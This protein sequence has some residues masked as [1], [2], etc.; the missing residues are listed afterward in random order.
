MLGREHP[1]TLRSRHGLARE[2]LRAHRAAEAEQQLRSV[3]IDRI[4][5]LGRRHP[6]TL[7]NRHWLAFALAEQGAWD[8]A[9][10]SMQAV[11]VRAAGRARDRSTATPC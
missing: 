10:R 5:A 4:H 11:L 2:L 7:T 8:D 6:D 3:L 9:E 1:W